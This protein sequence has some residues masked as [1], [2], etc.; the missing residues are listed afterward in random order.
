MTTPTPFSPGAEAVDRLVSTLRPAVETIVNDLGPREHAILDP[1][2]ACFDHPLSGMALARTID[3]SRL[4]PAVTPSEI[5]ELC[6]LALEYGFA[7]VCLNPIHIS[8]AAQRLHGSSAAVGAVVGFPFGATLPSVKAFEA[9]QVIEAGA[10]EVD[11]VLPIGHLRAGNWRA[12]AEDILAVVRICHPAGVLVK[13]ILETAYLSTEHKVVGCLLAQ[14]CGADF[15]KTS[16]GF[17]PTGATLAD[18]AMMRRVV[19]RALGVKAAGGIRTL[20]EAEA[21][22]A[23]GATRIGTSSGVVIMNQA[24]PRA[25]GGSGSPHR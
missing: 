6:D 14:A 8:Q 11:M 3:E 7:S 2:Q 12:V 20:E 15:V 19:G 13:V 25:Q 22:I 18:V 16:T 24:R 4:K 10:R 1:A 23:A 17:A 5:D 9:V 21:M